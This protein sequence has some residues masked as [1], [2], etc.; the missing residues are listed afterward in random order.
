MLKSVWLINFM[1]APPLL[2]WEGQKGRWKSNFSKET[3]KIKKCTLKH[4]GPAV[5]Y[6]ARNGPFLKS[7]RPGHPLSHLGHMYLFAQNWMGSNHCS[8][9]TKMRNGNISIILQMRTE[10]LTT[11]FFLCIRPKVLVR[12][13]ARLGQ[14][15]PNNKCIQRTPNHTFSFFY[16]TEK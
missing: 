7:P 14:I 12:V 13:V 11:E 15:L 4:N 10:S 2:P 9:F 8:L 3:I 6:S 16:Y 5:Q 1:V